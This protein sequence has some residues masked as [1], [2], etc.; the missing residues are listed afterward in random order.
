MEKKLPLLVVKLKQVNKK[1]FTLLEAILVLTIISICLLLFTRTTTSST[2][3]SLEMDKVKSI[4]LLAQREAI[5]TKQVEY[6]QIQNSQIISG[7]KTYQLAR[8]MT[9]G[10]HE[11]YFNERGNVNQARTITCTFNNQQKQLVIH[12]GSG[13]I[14]AK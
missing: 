3:L 8:G 2:S 4:L 7:K 12:L 1:G 6:V 10:E 9:C 14:Y 5:L 13:N 11:I